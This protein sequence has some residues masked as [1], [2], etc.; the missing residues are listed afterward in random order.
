MIGNKMKH[1]IL[2]MDNK[3]EGSVELAEKVFAAEYRQD[4]L[5]RVVEWQRAGWRAGTHKV[6]R[7]GEVSGTTKKPYSQKGTGNARHGTRRS[8]IFRGGAT[9]HGPVVRSHSY[10]LPKKVRQLGLR[11]ALSLKKSKN[12]LVILKNFEM[13]EA[14]TKIFLKNLEKLGITSALFVESKAV[15]ENFSKASANVHSVKALPHVGLN[16]YDILKHEHLV[17]TEDALKQIE[18]R[19]NA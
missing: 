14:K 9:M 10:K 17:I 1:D 6:K 7:V 3:V 19:L 11:I 5:H 18:E 16:V 2:S 15:S 8:M 4:I 13:K 12:Q